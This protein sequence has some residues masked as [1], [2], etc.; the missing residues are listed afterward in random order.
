MCICCRNCHTVIHIII[1]AVLMISEPN[2]DGAVTHASILR[3]KSLLEVSV[4]YD[5]MKRRTLATFQHPRQTS[6]PLT[7]DEGQ[8]G[9]IGWTSG[10]VL[11]VCCVSFAISKTH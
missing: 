9:A 2:A 5:M 6:L 11:P 4:C 3:Q 10:F 8:K 7:L 1:V